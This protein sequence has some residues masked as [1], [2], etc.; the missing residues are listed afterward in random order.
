MLAIAAHEAHVGGAVGDLEAE[1]FDRE[2][3]ARLHVGGVDHRVRQ[4]NRPVAIMESP[5]LVLLDNESVILILGPADLE[6]L[7]AARNVERP[8]GAGDFLFRS[9]KRDR[10][11][12]GR[13]R[14]RERKDVRMVAA[15]AKKTRLA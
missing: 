3:L 10:R 8:V 5:W 11:D 7:A 14:L 1:L 13:R 12:G 9:G 15:A 4:L 6:A 2:A